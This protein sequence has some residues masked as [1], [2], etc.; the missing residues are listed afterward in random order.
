MVS[1]ESALQPAKDVNWG[2]GNIG[3]PRALALQE[4]FRQ[5]RFIGDRPGAELAVMKAAHRF[6]KRD[7][8]TA[9][10]INGM[11]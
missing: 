7:G 5:N 1:P 4:N 2:A 3:C 6:E 9:T 11:S 8:K 10:A